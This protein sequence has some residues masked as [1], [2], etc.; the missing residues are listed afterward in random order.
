[1]DT[2]RQPPQPLDELTQML[3]Q[4]REQQP[5]V[6]PPSNP[7]DPRRVMTSTEVIA[8][9]LSDHGEQPY[10]LESSTFE[11]LLNARRNVAL[12]L[13]QDLDIDIERLEMEIMQRKS[14]RNDLAIIVA[15]AD[16][17]LGIEP[18]RG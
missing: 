14:R 16:L 12:R 18:E 5:Q 4:Q 11:I 2:E 10:V 15:R 1:M 7:V 9:E 17:A 3:D 13:M 6:T 8:R